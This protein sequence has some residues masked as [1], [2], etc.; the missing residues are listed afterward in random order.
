MAA[1][2]LPSNLNM[3]EHYVTG[4]AYTESNGVRKYF[5]SNLFSAGTPLVTQCTITNAGTTEGNPKVDRVYLYLNEN[6][7]TQ[8]QE[9]TV[10]VTFSKNVRDENGVVS[11]TTQSRD[12]K[13]RQY[14][15]LEVYLPRASD[16]KNQAQYFYIEQVEEYDNY[17]DPYDR[18]NTTQ[19]YDGLP[20]GL[21]GVSMGTNN[22]IAGEDYGRGLHNTQ[23]ILTKVQNSDNINNLVLYEAPTSAAEYCYNKNTRASN[24]TVNLSASSGWFLPDIRQLETLI[25]TYQNRYS[26]FRNEFYW[27]SNNSYTTGLFGIKR[28]RNN[29]ARAT[30]YNTNKNNGQG[31][32]VENGASSGENNNPET[33][34]GSGVIR[35][36]HALRIRAAYFYN[37]GQR[38]TN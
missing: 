11:R 34:Y 15:L 13:V 17:Y 32:Y 27:S 23:T 19:V 37:G 22:D 38:L 10:R 29:Y 18:Y 2:T 8:D 21:S 16:G 14:G 9:A 24:G 36:N 1:G 6:I 5:T 12:I 4:S 28:E 33:N 7:S 20:W 30:M 3:S 31:G 25:T 35:R 26:Y